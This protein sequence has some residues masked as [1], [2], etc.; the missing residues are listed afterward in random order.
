MT[1]RGRGTLN[2][3]AARLAIGPSAWTWTGRQLVIDIDEWTVPVPKRLRGRIIVEPGPV[4]AEEICLHDNRRHFWRPVAPCAR[5]EARFDHPDLG[6]RGSAYL[7]MNHGAEPLEAGFRRWDW[8]R[9]EADGGT[10]IHYETSPREGGPRSL[11]LEYRRDGTLAS[12]AAKPSR[13]LPR[14]GW[15]V[16]RS[17]P[18]AA[19]VERTLEDTPFYSRSMLGQDGSRRRAIHETVDLDRFRSRWVQ[20]LLPFKMPRLAGRGGASVPVLSPALPG[21]LRPPLQPGE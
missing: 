5:V 21:R 11:A 10:R 16:A 6:W 19:H 15:R 13:P 4:F 8:C 20:A 3:S 9:S 2:A 18:G 7:D 1:E 14:T 17:A 12:L